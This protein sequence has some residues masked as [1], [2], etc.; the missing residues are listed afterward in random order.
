MPKL[1]STH[2]G[3]FLFH[4]RTGEKQGTAILIPDK[5]VASFFFVFFFLLS[6]FCHERL[7]SVLQFCFC[8]ESEESPRYTDSAVT[9]QNA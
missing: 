8:H 6:L 3:L 1:G 9:V 5:T 2:E 4:L 7:I